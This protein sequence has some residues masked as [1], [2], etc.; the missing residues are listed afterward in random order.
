MNRHSLQILL[1]C[2]I[3]VGP[4]LWSCASTDEEKGSVGGTGLIQ[5]PSGGGNSE[6]YRRGQSLTHSLSNN[7]LTNRIVSRSNAKEVSNRLKGSVKGQ[8]AKSKEALE[9]MVSAQRLSG[10]SVETIFKSVRQIADIEL[11][12]GVNNDVRDQIKLEVG[13]AALTQKNYAL[14]EFMLEPLLTSKLAKVKAGAANALGIMAQK[15]GRIPEAVQMWKTALKAEP[16]YQA[17]LLNLGFTSLEYGD[18]ETA[19][20]MLTRLPEDWFTLSGLIVVNRLRGKNAEVKR[21]CDIVLKQ[22]PNHKPSVFNCGLFEWQ[23][24]K[25]AKKARS[26]INKA[27]KLPGGPQSW[28]QKGFRVLEDIKG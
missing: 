6:G 21:L 14:A 18:F 1:G 24:N 7:K 25:N 3:S 11:K 9:G 28:E 16:G 15:E 12:K 2:L 4:L 26:M 22:K 19:R 5:R 23:A 20:K 13:L 17:A 27:I 8:D 10:V